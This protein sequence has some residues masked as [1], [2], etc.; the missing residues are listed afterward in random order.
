MTSSLLA[1]LLVTKSSRGSNVA[2]HWPRKPRL[3]KRYS[4]IKYYAEMD[5]GEDPGGGSQDLWSHA[6]TPSDTEET[7]CSDDSSSSSQHSFDQGAAMFAAEDERRARSSRERMGSSRIPARSQS[8]GREALAGNQSQARS[9]SR[10]PLRRRAAERAADRSGTTSR[11]TSL[12]KSEAQRRSGFFSYLGFD[13][14]MLASILCPKPEQCHQKFELVVDDLAFIGHPVF[15]QRDNEEADSSGPAPLVAF[16]VVLVIDRPDPTPT[17][18]GFDVAAWMHLYY[19][20]VFKLTAVLY[21]EERRC[22]YVR[23]QSRELIALRDEWVQQGGAYRDYLKAALGQSSLARALRAMHRGISH[24]RDVLLTISDQIDVHLQ[25]PPILQQPDKMRLIPELQTVL[26]AGD[27]LVLRGDGPLP[28]RVPHIGTQP[29]L[30][31]TQTTGPFLQPWKTL[32][33][34]EGHVEPEHGFAESRALLKLF[35]PTLRGSRTFAQAADMLQWDLYGAVFPMVRH[36]IYYGKARVVDVPRIQSIYSMDPTFDLT[37]LP[38]LETRWMTQFPAMRSLTQLLADVSNT[39][40]P[41]I[42]HFAPRTHPQLCFDVLIWLLR[43]SVLVQVHVHLRLVVTE[44]D[45]QKAV[46]LRR[47]RHARRAAARDRGSTHHSAASRDDGSDDSSG[48]SGSESDEAQRMLID[49]IRSQMRRGQA[50]PS[51]PAPARS[52]ARS[53][54]RSSSESSPDEWPVDAPPP[55]APAQSMDAAEM[56]DSA[57]LEM[58]EEEDELH[59]LLPY[60]APR[61]VLI[62][63]PS[64]AN[65]VENEWISAMLEGKHAWYTR[66]LLRL[67]PYLNGKHTID[68]IISREHL[69]RRDLKLII[70]QFDRNLVRL[71]HP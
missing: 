35:T 9:T 46:D 7:V 11:A 62:P 31:W 67:L 37:H 3:V 17:L 60:G 70:A 55:A 24:N 58:D 30:E 20:L 34:P 5:E 64:R 40:K 51:R 43:H 48:V 28:H 13:L 65:R 2:F 8:R 41:F 14:E 33:M 66:W 61:A 15:F 19:A 16:N 18:P 21:A 59:A 25:L 26:D 63:E 50:Q 71:L 45:Q 1:V 39:L 52:H 47:R 69:S 42:S 49:M 22:G 57:L 38:E 29:F 36:L 6:N 54:S 44:E 27:P 32:L 23:Q 56:Q 10:T 4:R 68:E 53:G 12:E